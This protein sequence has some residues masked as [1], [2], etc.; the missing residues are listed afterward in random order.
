MRPLS[1]PLKQSLMRAKALTIA[2]APPKAWIILRIMKTQTFVTNMQA[3]LETMYTDMVA[4]ST[5]R[6]PYLSLIGPRK[7]MLKESTS[8]NM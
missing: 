8:M 5:L 2:P 1:G 3:R 6:L 4:A 7:R